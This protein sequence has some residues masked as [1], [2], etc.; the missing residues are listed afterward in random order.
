MTLRL[1]FTS[2]HR[3]KRQARRKTK[4]EEGCLYM[5]IGGVT[6]YFV[7][8]RRIVFPFPPSGFFSIIIYLSCLLF[9]LCFVL[10]CFGLF[11]GLSLSSVVLLLFFLFCLVGL[12]GSESCIQV[13]TNGLDGWM[14][15][16]VG[17][18]WAGLGRPGEEGRRDGGM[19]GEGGTLFIP[20]HCA[21]PRSTVLC[22]A[23]LYIWFCVWAVYYGFCV[24]CFFVVGER[25]QQDGK[26][27]KLKQKKPKQIPFTRASE[28]ISQAQD[29]SN[30]IHPKSQKA[31]SK[32]DLSW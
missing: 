1:H 2:L 13:V 16:W 15:G 17:L 23:V 27:R 28:V 32:S 25:S 21:A 19:E 24:A 6:Y 26:Y 4:G 14:D 3:W 12:G 31:H 9:L 29:S 5:G 7:L 20:Y 8:S 30:P 18:G 22:C 11:V 10:F